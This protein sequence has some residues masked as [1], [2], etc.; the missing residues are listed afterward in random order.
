MTKNL[1]PDFIRNSGTPY[2]DTFFYR[3]IYERQTKIQNEVIKRLFD[4]KT[5]NT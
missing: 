4:K 2:L 5:Q 1:A 3:Y